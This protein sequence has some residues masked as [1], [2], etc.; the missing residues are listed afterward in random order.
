M[1]D[2]ER[3]QPDRRAEGLLVIHLSEES[4]GKTRKYLDKDELANLLAY[5]E[6]SQWPAFALPTAY[7][8]N[9]QGVVRAFHIGGARY[10][11]FDGMIEPYL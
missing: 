10:G 7:V 8:V 4:R 5:A 11:H 6:S 9:R 3:L 2:L 1:P